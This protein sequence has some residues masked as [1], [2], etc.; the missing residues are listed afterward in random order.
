MPDALDKLKRRL[1]AREARLR[2]VEGELERERALS[3]ARARQLGGFE[4]RIDAQ[5]TELQRRGELLA[6]AHAAIDALRAGDFGDA[7]LPPVVG[8][9]QSPVIAAELRRRLTGDPSV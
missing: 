1:E 3:A 9:W 6:Q 4:D 2:T 7:A 8:W 5:A